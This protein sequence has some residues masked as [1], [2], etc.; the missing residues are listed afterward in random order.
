MPFDARRTGIVVD[1]RSRRTRIFNRI[2][3]VFDTEQS[4]RAR[5]ICCSSTSE[6][7]FRVQLGDWLTSQTFSGTNEC[8]DISFTAP[9]IVFRWFRLLHPKLTWQGIF[10]RSGSRRACTGGPI[11]WSTPAR[12]HSHSDRN[13]RTGTVEKIIEPRFGEDTEMAE[14]VLEKG[15]PFY[16]EIRIEN[17]LKDSAGEDVRLKPGT[18]VQVM[19][20]R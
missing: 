3:A 19:V 9:A 14:I 4:L 12:T 16:R 18:P 11:A 8:R 20:D 10:P 7:T 2:D 6:I 5:E 13:S 17:R 15:E 1:R